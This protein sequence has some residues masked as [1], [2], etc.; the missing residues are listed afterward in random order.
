VDSRVVS[1][2]WSKLLDKKYF[3]VYRRELTKR[4]HKS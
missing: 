2:D 4:D 1:H 3:L